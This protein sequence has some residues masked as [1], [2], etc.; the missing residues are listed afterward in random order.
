VTLSPPLE[1]RV[2][3]AY[4]RTRSR[5]PRVSSVAVRPN[6][7]RLASLSRRRDDGSVLNLATAVV[8]AGEEAWCMVAPA[9]EGDRESL[10][11]LRKLTRQGLEPNRRGR[12]LPETRCQGTP[13]QRRYLLRLIDYVRD[14]VRARPDLPDAIPADIQVRIS[15]R[16]TRSL[17]SCSWMGDSRRITVAERLFRPGLEGLLWETV[18]HELAHLADQVTSA[19][20]RS[21]HGSSWKAWARRLGARPERLC[22]PAEARRIAAAPAPARGESLAW[23]E[24]LKGGRDGGPRPGPADR[25][26]GE[27]VR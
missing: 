17:G 9:L 4:H 24:E 6:T 7:R 13:E 19:H 12:R 25:G 3:A 27:G 14:G 20:G 5:L 8:E 16:M 10:L 21:D 15:R 22:T 18:K 23:P 11:R 2:L 1:A 26:R